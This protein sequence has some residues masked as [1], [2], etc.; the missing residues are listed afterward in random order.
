MNYKENK[1]IHLG[2]SQKKD[3]SMKSDFNKRFLFFKK[4]GLDKKIIIS[5]D[6]VHKNRVM[7]VDD[8]SESSV[9][10][11]CD[12]L[13]SNNPKHLLSLTVADCLPIY[14]FD[15]NKSVI[16]L[17]HAGWRGIVANIA[18]EVINTFIDHYDSNL[19]DI[20]IHLGPHIK[21]C[22]FEV[23]DDV[24]CQFQEA[25]I[26]NKAGKKY[27]DLAG[28]VKRQALDLNILPANI[29][30]SPECT[31]CLDDKYFSFRRDKPQELQTMLAYISLK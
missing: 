25:Y 12:A 15:K 29:Y 16:A 9:I 1:K 8:V 18:K 4:L 6:L 7:I 21:S 30:I 27:V 17:A 10:S 11:K 5:A 13:I 26:L 23:K 28:V 19:S 14:F 20:E 31:H 3:G 24:A 2:I 22:H